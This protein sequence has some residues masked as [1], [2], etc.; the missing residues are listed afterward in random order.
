MNNDI[1]K[2]KDTKKIKEYENQI[3]QLKKEIENSNKNLSTK[4]IEYI[5]STKE[6]FMQISDRF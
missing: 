4:K 3:N 2:E 6:T 1:N 5:C